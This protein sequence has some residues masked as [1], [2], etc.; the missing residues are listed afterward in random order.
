MNIY[1]IRHTR[2]ATEGYCYGQTDVP[3][4]STFEEEAEVVKQKLRAI[5]HDAV[6]SSPLSR[7]VK[8]AEYCGYSDELQ[9]VDSLKEMNFGEWEM[10][11]WEDLRMEEWREDWAEIPAPGGES[12]R[13]VYSR[14]AQL[15]E[16]L[17]IKEYNSIKIFTH[18]GVINCAKIYFGQAELERAFDRIAA[19]GEVIEFKFQ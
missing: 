6:L 4:F 3:L 16:E 5:P 13:E 8:L 19:Y 18:G 14:V 15:L 2:V 12:F 11:R 1:F 17:K 10:K 7:C 9:Q